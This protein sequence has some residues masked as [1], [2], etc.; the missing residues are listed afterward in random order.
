MRQDKEKVEKLAK[1]D[2]TMKHQGMADE[3]CQTQNTPWLKPLAQTMIKI[4]NSGE[5]RLQLSKVMTR[6]YLQSHSQL[7]PPKPLP[8][9][10]R[11]STQSVPPTRHR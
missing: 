1:R 3:G 10:H 2:W 11:I 6:I 5:N 4:K 8:L 9:L 7:P